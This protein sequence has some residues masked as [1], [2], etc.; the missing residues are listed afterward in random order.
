MYSS[1]TDH[2]CSG[3]SHEPMNGIA[4]IRLA[5]VPVVDL[6]ITGGIFIE[7]LDMVYAL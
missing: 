3:I 4:A 7:I 6:N 5:G 2:W 1:N